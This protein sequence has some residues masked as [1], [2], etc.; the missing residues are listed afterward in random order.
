MS[1]SKDVQWGFFSATTHAQNVTEAL[2]DE[3]LKFVDNALR[4]ALK[5][6]RAMQW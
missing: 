2:I 5:G 1:V 4:Q 3:Y 6:F